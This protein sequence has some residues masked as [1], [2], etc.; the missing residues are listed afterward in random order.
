MTRSMTRIAELE[1]E[2]EKLKKEKEKYE[3]V[4]QF[5]KERAEYTK[6]R[7]ICTTKKHKF[8]IIG[9]YNPVTW[10]D[11]EFKTLGEAKAYCDFF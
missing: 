2:N 1:K 8:L 9:I 11:I 6:K 10:E 7:A 5:E 4:K 3:A